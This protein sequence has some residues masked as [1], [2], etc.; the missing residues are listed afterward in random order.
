MK[1]NNILQFCEH[2]Q[3]KASQ[4]EIRK[5]NTPSIAKG[6]LNPMQAYEPQICY[7]KH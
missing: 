6:A 3:N 4:N 5:Q 2:R 1:E 7:I